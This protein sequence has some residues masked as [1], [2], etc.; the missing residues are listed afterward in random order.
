MPS[1]SFSLTVSDQENVRPLQNASIEDVAAIV[2]SVTVDAVASQ[3][4]GS[5]KRS[6]KWKIC[7]RIDDPKKIV[8]LFHKTTDAALVLKPLSWKSCW[9]ATPGHCLLS[10]ER[11]LVSPT[12]IPN[13]TKAPNGVSVLPRVNA[14]CKRWPEVK[15]GSRTLTGPWRVSGPWIPRF[16]SASL[17][18][19]ANAFLMS[20]STSSSLRMSTNIPLILK[21]PSSPDC[22]FVSG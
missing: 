11:W 22:N 17:R 18:L 6:N 7:L 20:S 19:S 12:L 4:N 9:A 13:Y 15:L 2:S 21:A 5:T 1:S 16:D 3:I 10:G 8:A 14:V